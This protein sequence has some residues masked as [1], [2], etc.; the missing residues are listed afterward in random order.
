MAGLERNRDSRTP[1]VEAFAAELSRGLYGST[2]VMGGVVTGQVATPGEGRSTAQWGG[3]Q[4][5]VDSSPAFTGQSELSTTSG[6]R[7][8]DKTWAPTVIGPAA[9]RPLQSE[10]T[11]PQ[12]SAQPAPVG[13]TRVAQYDQPLSSAGDQ[14]VTKP[15]RRN[16][17]WVALGGVLILA[18]IGAILYLIL[19]GPSA[20]GF[21]LVVKGAPAGS[22]VF[23]NET[24]RDAVAADGALR[25]T[26]VDPGQVNV[27]VSHEGFT[28]FMTTL[29]GSKGEVQNCEAQLLPGID[30]GGAM[31]PIPAGEFEM[32]DNNHE[33]DERPTHPVSLPSYYIDKYE[34]TNAQYKKFCDETQHAYP[35]DPPFDPNYFTG[36][37]DYPVL[38]PTFED[39]LAYAKW[40][41]KRLPTEEEWEK[42]ASWDPVA[43]EASVSLGRR[44]HG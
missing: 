23:V 37:P 29:T 40:A 5:N 32:G 10:S 26:G 22:Q 34:V 4:T 44:V 36:K 14:V 7:A 17:K 41:G 21:T 6:A 12:V 39:A 35:P 16:G 38:G 1:T 43:Q 3:A 42:A 25:V 28:D 15:E 31:V 2:Q 27:R 8:D 20:S 9:T 30:Y 18:V 19:P 33:P 13:P 24:R 11:P